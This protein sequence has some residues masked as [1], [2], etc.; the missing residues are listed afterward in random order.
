[1]CLTGVLPDM[2][3]VAAEAAMKRVKRYAAFDSWSCPA[4]HDLQPVKAKENASST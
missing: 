1:M 3:G 2:V 4:F